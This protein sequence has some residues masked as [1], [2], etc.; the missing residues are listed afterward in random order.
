MTPRNISFWV[1]SLA[2][3][4]SPLLS[5]KGESDLTHNRQF[6]IAIIGGGLTGLWLAY[7]LH[8]EN[9]QQRITIFEKEQI[10]YG[11]SGRN[12]GWL[13]REVPIDADILLKKKGITP[14]DITQLYQQMQAAIPEIERVCQQENINC[15]LVHG[16]VLTIARNRAQAA[17]L[18]A[19]TM[20][21]YCF[22]LS[23]KELQK[24][25]NIAAPYGAHY[26]EI[27]ARIHPLKLL[28]GLK[29][30]LLERG[31]LIYEH[32]AVTKI[33]PHTITV[34]TPSN[35]KTIHAAKI[36]TCTEAYSRPFLD[37]ERVIPLNS[38]IIVTE[39]ISP[40]RWE[41]IGWQRRELLADQAHLF[42]YAQRTF[43]DRILIGGRG[44]PYQF[45]A[46]DA[47]D[48][49]LDAKTTQQLLDKLHALFPEE[50]FQVA[51]AWKGSIGVSRDWCATVSYQPQTNIGHI[52][53]L[54][55]S[56]VT[57]SHLAARTMVDKLQAKETPLTQL[58]WNDHLSP[59]WEPEPLK[60]CA[61]H[62]LYALLRYADYRES[63]KNLQNSA[64]I[65]QLVYKVMGQ[66]EP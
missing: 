28:L 47:G 1:Q 11:A 20:D 9:P 29:K 12:G 53:G 65:A 42:F 35:T 16:G 36:V 6:D 4:N 44:S 19:L 45:G 8:L 5:L 38:S 50:T 26:D 51:Y 22:R 66:K 56:G 18:D 40:E 48:G 54:V 31:I 49:E 30:V 32:H 33:H 14:A 64:Y 27:G 24:H 57:T 61:I 60:W 46:K 62:G 25:I 23:A 63:V 13:S 2:A 3:I 59:V 21:Q 10:G 15:D 41:K 7:Y 58:P 39:V 55:G 43:D 37:K 34:Q 52:Y 17:R